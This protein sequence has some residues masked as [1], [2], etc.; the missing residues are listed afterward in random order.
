MKTIEQIL[1]LFPGTTAK[2]W[3]QHKNGGGWKHRTAKVDV[4]AYL[5]ENAQIFGNAQI[6][7]NAWIFGDAQISGDAQ[8]FGDAQI[9]GDAWISGNAWDQ[10]PLYIQG[11]RHALS[12][13]SRGHIQIGCHQ[14]TI[15]E[16]QK[17]YKA[18]GRTEGYT[19]KQIK[20]Y[21]AYIELFALIDA[22]LPKEKVQA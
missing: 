6:S 19:P 4:S 18:I 13:C 9:S 1:D 12:H 17:R 10:S 2:D 20:E 15:E 22:Q 11:T 5:G 3:S 21:G 16:W 7:G 14:L 8:I